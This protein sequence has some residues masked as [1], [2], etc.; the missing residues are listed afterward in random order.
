MQAPEPVGV[1]AAVDRD[2]E[3]LAADHPER[4]LRELA[5][6]V[7]RRVAKRE[8]ERLRQ[9]RV[10]GEDR[11]VLAEADVRARLAA[12]EVVVVE[13]GQVVVDEAER[14]D[15]LER[16]PGGKQLGRVEAERLAGREAEHRPDALA[17]AE[18]RVAQRLLERP[19]LVGERKPG[20]ELLGRARAARQPGASAS[21]R[22]R[23]TSAWTSLARSESSWRIC[24]ARSGSSALSSSARAAS[25]FSSSSW[26]R[27]DR[28]RL[29]HVWLASLATRPR[30]P[31]TRRPASSLA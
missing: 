12:A 10:P 1:Q 27:G 7:G 22:A 2:V 29:A 9:E 24:T 15:E 8:A 25:T 21:L 16:A 19:E 13:G 18:E 3:V 6:D 14:V 20:E 26:S 4:R 11:D 30:I 23:S 28:V 17:A 5:R 31:L